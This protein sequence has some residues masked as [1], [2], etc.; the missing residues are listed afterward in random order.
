LAGC[1][2]LRLIADLGECIDHTFQLC[3]ALFQ[4]VYALRIGLGERPGAAISEENT[5]DEK[6]LK[7]RSRFHGGILATQ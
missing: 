2:A 5:E 4:S 7:F 1:S 3:Y 6:I